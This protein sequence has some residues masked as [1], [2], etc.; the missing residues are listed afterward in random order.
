MAAIPGQQYSGKHDNLPVEDTGTDVIPNEIAQNDKKLALW[1]F[2]VADLRNR[3]LW[4]PTYTI[5]VAEMVN[6]AYRLA[7]IA[8]KVDEEGVTVPKYTSRGVPTGE[9]KHPLLSE[10]GVLRDKLMK[11]V[12]KLGMSPR[13]IVFLTQTEAVESGRVKV[14]NSDKPKIVYFR[15][16]ED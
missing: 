6:C 5:T 7:Q 14:L 1:Q 15:D 13:D 4:S 10:E 11:F 16:E 3:N 9:M 2:L 8:A 12:E